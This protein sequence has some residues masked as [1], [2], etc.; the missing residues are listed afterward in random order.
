MADESLVEVPI[1]NWAEA[2][3]WIVRKLKYIGRR[4]G[5]DRLFAKGKR[6]VLIEFKDPDGE[7]SALQGREFR[8]FREAEVEEAYV[9][10][11]LA[12]G[13]RILGLRWPR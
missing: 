9:V 11:N 8:R 6:I 13:C 12:D 1:C 3:G 5:P 2:D 4:A 10:D 7:L